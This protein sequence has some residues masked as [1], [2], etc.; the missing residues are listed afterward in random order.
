MDKMNEKM[1]DILAHVKKCQSL[2]E[3]TDYSN[4]CIVLYRIEGDPKSYL[5]HRAGRKDYVEKM[6]KEEGAIDIERFDNTSNS[7]MV[8]R[9][10][11]DE[12]VI[13]KETTDIKKLRRDQNIPTR[14]LII[15]KP[16]D[17]RRFRLFLKGVDKKYEEAIREQQKKKASELHS[18]KSE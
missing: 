1:D 14:V 13:P 12:K 11:K 18:C 8:I 3:N 4:E 17:R 6:L 15:N 2:I 16:S 7:K 5:R 9:Y 10:A